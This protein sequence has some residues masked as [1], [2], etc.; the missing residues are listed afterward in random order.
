[1]HPR[2][3][4]S[5]TH[6]KKIQSRVQKDF[7]DLALF[8]DS[9]LKQSHF[10]PCVER[11]SLLTAEAGCITACVAIFRARIGETSSSK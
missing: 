6:A 11:I 1:M 10:T 8:R 2:A 4:G 3:S 9:W 7:H 5:D